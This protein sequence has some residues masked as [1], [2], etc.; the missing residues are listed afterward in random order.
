MSLD[1][2]IMNLFPT[3]C[4]Q[5]IMKFQLLYRVISTAYAKEHG[6]TDFQI[7]LFWAYTQEMGKD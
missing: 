1:W 3:L 5:C 7:L 2:K 4:T 6:S